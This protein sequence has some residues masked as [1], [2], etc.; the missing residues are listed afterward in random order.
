MI[1]NVSTWVQ[2]VCQSAILLSAL[3]KKSLFFFFLTLFS[4]SLQILVESLGNS[5]KSLKLFHLAFYL[6]I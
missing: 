3:K 1:S 5:S 4:S 2:N 6:F